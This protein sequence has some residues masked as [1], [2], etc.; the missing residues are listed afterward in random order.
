MRNL[1]GTHFCVTLARR[2]QIRPYCDFA[3][4]VSR[5]AMGVQPAFLVLSSTDGGLCNI[6]AK[7]IVGPACQESLVV[8]VGDPGATR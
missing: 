8:E 5:P 7:G 2:K 6:V 4:V 3:R 1:R